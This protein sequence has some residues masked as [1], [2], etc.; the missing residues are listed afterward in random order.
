MP[1][2]LAFVSAFSLLSSILYQEL[3][4]SIDILFEMHR[5]MLYGL[6]FSSV[7]SM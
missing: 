5:N 6:L 1:A 4:K 7:S 2:A 3:P